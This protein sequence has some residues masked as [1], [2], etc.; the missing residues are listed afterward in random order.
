MR[1]LLLEDVPKLGPAGN[2]VNVADGYARNFLI[3]RKLA[4]PVSE[5]SL[6]EI[7]HV[8]EL[9]ARRRARQV[10][11]AQEL[12][13]RIESVSLRFYA[14]AGET[15]KLYGSITPADIAAALTQTLGQEI[16]RRKIECDPLRQLGEHVVPI[17]VGTDVSAHV[18]V[19]IE[20]EATSAEASD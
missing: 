12:A 11:A 10:A 9:G 18:K 17:R 7:E 4:K 2:V 6:Q 3:P 1:V 5:G 15:G 19:I 13:Q 16:D 8:R 14:R 20:P